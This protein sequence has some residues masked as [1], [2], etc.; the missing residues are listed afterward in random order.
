MDQISSTF[1]MRDIWNGNQRFRFPKVYCFSAKLVNIFNVN[2]HAVHNTHELWKYFFKWW[3]FRHKSVRVSHLKI[4]FAERKSNWN[5]LIW[6]RLIA[7]LLCHKI[8]LNIHVDDERKRLL[9]YEIFI[10]LWDSRVFLW[11]VSSLVF[12]EFWWLFL[13]GET[14]EFSRSQVANLIPNGTDFLGIR[15]SLKIKMNKIQK[16]KLFWATKKCWH[17]IDNLS[18]R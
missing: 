17:S 5:K 13:K 6:S 14:V 2:E 9:S 7:F 12:M 3:Q 8:T 18:S 15:W 4:Q 1:M 10:F 11:D 16:K